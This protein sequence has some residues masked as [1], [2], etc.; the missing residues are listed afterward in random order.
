MNVSQIIYD[1]GAYDAW[2][3]CYDYYDCDGNYY[4]EEI[5]GE[6]TLYDDGPDPGNESESF[7][8]LLDDWSVSYTNV[9]CSDG[10]QGASSPELMD[11]VYSTIEFDECC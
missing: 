4:S 1:E 6:E 5:D 11:N 3:V 10:F 9:Q 2:G 7:H 8:W